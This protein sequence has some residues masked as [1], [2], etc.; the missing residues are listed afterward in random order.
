MWQGGFV[1]GFFFE[2]GL[3]DAQNINDY[4]EKWFRD[5]PIKRHITIGLTNVLNGAFASFSE[6]I[7]TENM[8]KI[9]QASVSFSGMSPAIS[10]FDQLY[11]SGNAI[12]ENDVSSAIKHCEQMGYNEEDIIIDA[13]ISGSP[14]MDYFDTQKANAWSIFA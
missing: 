12:Y 8:I 13:L 9:L 6:K 7:T 10:I 11:F 2:K 14:Y 3:Y 4:I 1:Y 5:R